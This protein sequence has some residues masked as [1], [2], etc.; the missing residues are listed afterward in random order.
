MAGDLW[1][2]LAVA[3]MGALHGMNPATGWAFGLFGARAEGRSP[4]LRLLVPVA[5]GHAASLAAVALAVP[6]ALRFGLE[7]DPLLP[8]GVAAALLLALG[9]HCVG[10]RAHRKPWQP[11]ARVGV[12]LWSFIVGTAHGAGWLLVPALVPLC[13]GDMPGREITASGSLLLGLG[14]VGVHLAAML[15]TTAAVAAVVRTGWRQVSPARARAPA[16]VEPQQAVQRQPAAAAPDQVQQEA[17][18]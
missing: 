4:M 13:A 12:A 15:A 11:A 2:W 16:S 1:P 5:A 14:A 10:R 17:C 18:P 7:F 6:A 3:G 9:L 8:Q